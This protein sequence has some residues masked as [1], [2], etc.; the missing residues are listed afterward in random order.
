MSD[1]PVEIRAHA[2]P[3][4]GSALARALLRL[5][6]WRVLGDSLPAAQGVIAVYPHTSNW[7]FPLG[8][9]CK[10][11]LGLPAS[12]WGK[13]SLFRVPLLGRWMRWIGGLPVVRSS[14]QGLVGDTV[15]QMRQARD[16]GR[17][18]W[19]V[20]APEG[21]RRHTDGWRMGFYRVAEG[22]GVPVALA[23]IDFGRREIGLDSFWH[24]SGDVQADFAAFARRLEGRRGYH[25]EQAA[26]IQP[27]ER[28]RP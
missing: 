20:V 22:A 12:F 16:E 8:V 10:W 24:L 23:V 1:A 3:L 17:R 2:L 25:P 18:L 5:M 26:P 11:A 13:D 28:K 9:L 7:D 4:K 14:P 19:L 27:L 6:G 21:T 15:V